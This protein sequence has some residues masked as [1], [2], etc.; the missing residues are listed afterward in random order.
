MPAVS[1]LGQ[2]LKARKSHEYVSLLHS[3]QNFPCDASSKRW[4]YSPVLSLHPP[5]EFPAPRLP[6]ASHAVPCWEPYGPSA[7][8][9]SHVAGS[10]TTPP[11]PFPTRR[12]C[13]NEARFPGAFRE[14]VSSFLPG[15]PCAEAKH[16]TT[17]FGH[18]RVPSLLEA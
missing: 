1:Q 7:G 9:R 12:Q 13:E 2:P 11:F 5:R 10:F 16:L 18:A 17:M 3:S 4:P 15:M 8:P 14:P 6:R